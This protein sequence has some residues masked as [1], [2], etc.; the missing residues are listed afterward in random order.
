M[1]GRVVDERRDARQRNRRTRTGPSVCIDEHRERME[2]EAVE[3]YRLRNSEMIFQPLWKLHPFRVTL[4]IVA[5]VRFGES[6]DCFRF[7]DGGTSTCPAARCSP[8]VDKRDAYLRA[9]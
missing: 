4:S 6:E 3:F 2:I 8:G 9:E 7:L 5:P 1:T